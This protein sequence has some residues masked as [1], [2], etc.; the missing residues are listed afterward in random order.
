MG[1]HQL[2]EGDGSLYEG[3][4]QDGKRLRRCMAASGSRITSPCC[5]PPSHQQEQQRSPCIH[6]PHRHIA[7]HSSCL[8]PK[9]TVPSFH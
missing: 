2:L 4:W 7:L 5:Q 1:W 9:T 6:T 8:L 3:D